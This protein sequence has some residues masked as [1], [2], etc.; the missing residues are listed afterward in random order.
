MLYRSLYTTLQNA[1]KLNLAVRFVYR[2]YQCIS[3]YIKTDLC[4]ILLQLGIPYFPNV[5]KKSK[6]FITILKGI[7]NT[8]YEK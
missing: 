2:K 8:C 3:V 7:D 6:D 1:Q 5:I 4:L